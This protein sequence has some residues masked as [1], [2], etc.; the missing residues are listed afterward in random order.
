MESEPGK[1]KWRINLPVLQD[2]FSSKIAVFPADSKGKTYNGPTLF[3]GGSESDYLKETDHPFIKK[4]FPSAQFHYI[5]GAGHWLHADKPAEF[6]QVVTDF[7]N[8]K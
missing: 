5:T 8:Q 2:S 3:V 7:I 4:I 6:L 1:F